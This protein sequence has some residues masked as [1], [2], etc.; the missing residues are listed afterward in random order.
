MYD[1][2]GRRMTAVVTFGNDFR[3]VHNPDIIT[4]V[5][6]ISDESEE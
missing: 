5:P 3:N 2:D 6:G 4:V 1:T